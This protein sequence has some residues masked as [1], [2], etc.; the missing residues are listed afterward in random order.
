MKLSQ[1][2]RDILERSLGYEQEDLTRLHGDLAAVEARAAKL[3]ESISKTEQI[4]ADL[5]EA[6]W[7]KQ[8]TR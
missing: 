4:V 7:P 6:L 5:T 3:R 2:A 1:T 8:C